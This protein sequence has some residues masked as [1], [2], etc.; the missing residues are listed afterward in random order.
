MNSGS[1]LRFAPLTPESWKDF[2]LLF[3]PRGACA[4]CWCMWW[5]LPRSEFNAKKGDGN[6]RSMKKLVDSG[7]IPGIL[8]YEGDRAVGWCS[9]APRDDFPGLDRSRV[10]ARVDDAPVWSITCFFVAR[11]RRHAG[12]TGALIKEAVRF[13]RANGARIVEAYPVEPG[14]KG[15]ADAFAFTGLASAFLK[16]GFA[17][18]ARRSPSRAVY[19]RTAGRARFRGNVYYR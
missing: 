16:T 8:A 14:E 3:G 5:R 10:L 18:A 7:V 15:T 12:I 13:A 19:R 11:D 17:E 9:I 2:T 1:Q 6:R 4:G